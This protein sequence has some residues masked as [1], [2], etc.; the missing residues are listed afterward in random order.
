MSPSQAIIVDERQNNFGL[1]TAHTAIE[2]REIFIVP[3]LLWHGTSVFAVSPKGP[4]KWSRLV[5][6]VRDKEDWPL[7]TRSKTSCTLKLFKTK[8]NEMTFMTSYDVHFSTKSYRSIDDNKFSH[9]IQWRSVRGI[10]DS[11]VTNFIQW[12]CI[13]LIS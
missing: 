12:C 1:C 10:D 9:F 3:N 7:L 6:Q 5:W 2:Q 4:T 8:H 11:H 13:I